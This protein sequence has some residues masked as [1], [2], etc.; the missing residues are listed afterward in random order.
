MFTDPTGELWFIPI[1][2]GGLV[3]GTG[4]LVANIISGNVDNFLDGVKSFAQGALAGAALGATWQFAP[5]IPG[6]GQALKTGMEIYGLVHLGGTA[7][8]AAS[9]L[10]QGIFTGDWSALGNAGKLFLGNFYLDD[11]RTFFGGVWQ[12]ISRHTWEYPQTFIGHSASQVINALGMTRSVTFYG[13]AT[14]SETFRDNWGGICLGSFI[15]GSRGITA[16]PSNT[17]FQHEFGHY[18]QSQA[19]GLMYFSRY[20]IPSALSKKG[21][22]HSLHPV[23]QDAN[24]RALKYF[25]KHISGYRDWNHFKNPIVG[26]NRNLPFN[27]PVNLAALQNARLRLSWHDYLMSPLNA[28]FGGIPVPG[29]I[30]AFLLN[31]KY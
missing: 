22:D 8:S 4:N 11:N 26:Y 20:G 13:G 19:S 21:V 15:I 27:D 25:N 29:L 16:D 28:L 1:L 17:L 5:L 2:I 14:V 31:R 12:G 23:E 30:N 6:I 18:L 3:F 7:L 9:G 10:E 24:A